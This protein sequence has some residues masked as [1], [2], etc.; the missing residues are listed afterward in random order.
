MHTQPRPAGAILAGGAARRLGG[1]AKG[2]LEIDGERVIDRVARAMQ[3]YTSQLMIV[4]STPAAREWITGVDGVADEH[5]GGGAVAAIATALRAARTD[6]LVVAWDMPFVSGAVIAP[7][8]ADAGEHDAVMWQL[9]SGLEP[10]CALY[11]APA[12]PTLDAAIAGGARRARD[13]ASLLR[14]RV[15]PY[16]PVAGEPS[17]FLSINTPADLALARRFA[18]VDTPPPADRD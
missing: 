7:L 18:G 11:R 9:S 1:A 6:V 13:V 3:P 10:L 16:E 2:L 4:A 15:L 17:P 8:L 5:P 14:L 12:L